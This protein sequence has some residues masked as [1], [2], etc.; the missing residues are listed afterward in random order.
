MEK[1]NS[2]CLPE[3]M[4]YS[5]EDEKF[6]MMAIK[7]SED[8]I[9][10]GGGPFGAV[11]VRDGEVI[12]TGTNRVVPNADPTAHAEVMAIR[13]ACAA[14]GTFQLEGCT[15]Y[16]SCEPCPMC[17]SALYWAGVERIFYGNT[18]DDAKAINF[19]DSF[20]Y[21]QLKLDYSERSIP[22][23]NIM[24]DRALE[25]FKAWSQKEDKVLY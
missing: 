16:S 1:D 21:D 25:G 19:D 11:I 13:N 18:K 10:S 22:C 3:T 5:K 8:N 12:A 15:V 4:N 14:I 6:M 2:R 24:R 20:I 9:D 17:L 23:I 7:L